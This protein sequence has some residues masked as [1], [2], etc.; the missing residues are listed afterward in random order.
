[1]AGKEHDEHGTLLVTESKKMLEEGWG[2]IRRTQN[3]AW[4]D[5]SW[6]NKEQLEH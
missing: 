1:M 2:H 3:Y 6:P 5:S 4:G